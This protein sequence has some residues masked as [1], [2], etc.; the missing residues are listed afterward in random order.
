MAKVAASFMK[1]ISGDLKRKIIFLEE[2]LIAEGRLLNG[3]Q[4][5]FLVYQQFQ[6]DAVEVGMTEF[7]DLQ[8]LRLKGEN[9]RAFVD[10]WDACV[11]DM[12]TPPTPQVKE[13]L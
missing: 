9:L 10:E 2:Q 1:L 8:N 5:L 4:I 13:I 7:R 12:Q 3:R 6:R 11:F